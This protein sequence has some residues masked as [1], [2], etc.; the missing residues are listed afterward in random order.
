MKKSPTNKP[1]LSIIILYYNSGNYLDKCLSSLAKSELGKYKIETIIVNN[2]ATDGIA[3]AAEKKYRRNIVINTKF[4]YSPT[5]LGF[6]A[7]NNFG[8]KSTNSDSKYILFVNDDVTFFPDTIYRMISF[9]ENN[10]KVDASTCYVTLAKNNQLA[11]ETHRGFP[12]PW[13]TFWHFFGLGIPKLFPRSKIFHGY[14]GDYK[15]Y[16]KTETIDC[17]QGCFLM[18]KRSVGNKIGWWNEKYFFLGEDLDFCY[19]LKQ[20]NFSLY[21][22]PEAKIIHFHGIS[23]GIKKHSG[24]LTSANRTTKIR[25]SLASTTAM[26][27]FYRENLMSKYPS[28]LHPLIFLGIKILEIYRIFKAKYL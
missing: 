14:L 18:V 6:S 17:C 15:E 13:N 19:K 7:G 8:L 11:P 1:I 27:I 22:Y 9:F 12:T 21:F 2:G 28:I 10:S 4:T 5:N 25:S 16:T 3:Q 24:K 26:K 23:S 20:N